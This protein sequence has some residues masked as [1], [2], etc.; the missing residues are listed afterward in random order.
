[1]YLESYLPEYR[2]T[3]KGSRRSFWHRLYASWWARFPWRLNDDEEPPTGDLDGMAR[4]GAIAPGEQEEKS[5]VEQR[6]HDVSWVFLGFCR[7]Y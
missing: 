4:L 6:V 3:K 5:G 1:L 7:G 2:A